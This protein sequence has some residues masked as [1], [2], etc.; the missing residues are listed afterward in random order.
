MPC[1]AAPDRYQAHRGQCLWRHGTALTS[2]IGAIIHRSWTGAGN[3]AFLIPS[4]AA[5]PDLACG[6]VWQ[7]KM[8]LLMDVAGHLMMLGTAPVPAGREQLGG[9]ALAR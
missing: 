3:H 9:A 8:R 7:G 6:S 1:A 2:R 4:R 5:G